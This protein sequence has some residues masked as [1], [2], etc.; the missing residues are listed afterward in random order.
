MIMSFGSG[1]L[2]PPHVVRHLA[3]SSP[4]AVPRK[5]T[6]SPR[7]GSHP[8]TYGPTCGRRIPNVTSWDSPPGP[9]QGPRLAITLGGAAPH[10][11]SSSCLPAAAGTRP[12]KWGAHLGPTRGP[13]SSNTRWGQASLFGHFTT[14]CG[15][16][17]GQRHTSTQVESLS[18]SITG[19]AL[20]QMS[21]PEHLLPRTWP[22]KEPVDVS[23]RPP[24]PPSL[25]VVRTGHLPVQVCTTRG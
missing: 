18:R 13:H 15:P 23:R 22:Q 10:H 25:P 21:S 11:I 6:T 9:L 4:G 5:P 24:T 19:A 20:L 8:S 12:P 16:P 2:Q 3:S 7:Q 1:G 17:R 14:Y